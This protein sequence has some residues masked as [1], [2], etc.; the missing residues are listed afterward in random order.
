MLMT[1]PG[2]P[3]GIALGTGI[4]AGVSADLQTINSSIQDGR[5]AHQCAAQ[6]LIKK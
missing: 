1:L 2:P 6:E 3:N 4:P 5:P